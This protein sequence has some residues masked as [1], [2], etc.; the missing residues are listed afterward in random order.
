MLHIYHTYARVC[1]CVYVYMWA[2]IFFTSLFITASEIENVYLDGRC[3]YDTDTGHT[4][5]LILLYMLGIERALRFSFL[6]SKLPYP[7]GY[8][9]SL[10]SL[11]LQYSIRGAGV[12]NSVIL[13]YRGA[14]NSLTHT[15]ITHRAFSPSILVARQLGRYAQL[16]RRGPPPPRRQYGD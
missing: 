2:C 1:V 15:I 3:F 7:S 6:N 12:S 14:Y 13:F 4:Q 8:V 11:G 10:T 16:D 9:Y 5:R